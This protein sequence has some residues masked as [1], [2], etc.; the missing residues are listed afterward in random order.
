MRDIG[1]SEILLI[2]IMRLYEIVIDSL[3]TIE[4][5]SNPIQS[6]IGVKQGCPFLPISLMIYI[7]ELEAFLNDSSL[8]G[9]GCHLH[10]VL[11]SILLFVD[12][13]VLLASSPK[14]LQRLLDKLA[15]FYDMR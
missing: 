8:S 13:V 6:T 7:D 11:I 2:V 1:I 4:G 3:R 5:L 14:R 9:D 10:Q 15:S 12:D